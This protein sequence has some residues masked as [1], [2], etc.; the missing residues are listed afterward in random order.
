MHLAKKKYHNIESIHR[1][2]SIYENQYL[3]V[4]F[5]VVCC[6]FTGVNI[7]VNGNVFTVPIT[8]RTACV[9]FEK[10]LSISMTK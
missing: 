10:K 8:F 5:L 6:V 2:T 3:G 1:P 9:C 7:N 4:C